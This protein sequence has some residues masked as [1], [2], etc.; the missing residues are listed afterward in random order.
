MLPGLRFPVWNEKAGTAHAD[1]GTGGQ[2]VHVKLVRIIQ[3]HTTIFHL[4][5]GAIEFVLAQ[6]RFEKL[7]QLERR[8]KFAHRKSKLTDKIQVV[9]VPTEW[10]HRRTNFHGP[11]RID[12]RIEHSYHA[13][14]GF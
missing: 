8:L 12:R 13:T 11:L 3:S 6:P 14:I 10:F 4:E 9:L 2:D 1:I 5:D 7:Q